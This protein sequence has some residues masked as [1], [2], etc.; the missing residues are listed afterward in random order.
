MTGRQQRAV[1]DRRQEVGDRVED[2]VKVLQLYGNGL[3]SRRSAIELI[4]IVDDVDEEIRRLEEE[5]KSE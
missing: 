3:L 2:H 1:K 4:G 5:S